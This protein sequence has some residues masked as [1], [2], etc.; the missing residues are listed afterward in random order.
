[1]GTKRSGGRGAQAADAPDAGT[2][3]RP[4]AERQR[5]HEAKRQ[6]VLRTAAQLFL[7]RGSPRVSMNDVAERLN[8][9]KP[10]LY[11]YFKSK[12]AILAECIRMGAATVGEGLTRVES[13]GGSGRER[14][15]SFIREYARLG[16]TDY[17]AC[18][19]RLDDRAL[20]DRE[21]DDARRGKRAI[22][23]RVRAIIQAGIAD[24]SI[25]R[26]DVRLATFAVI[27]ALNWIGQWYGPD[28]ANTPEEI[29]D[30]FAELLINGLGR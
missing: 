19:V 25:V 20:P 10:T 21:R 3:W 29:G 14:L 11:T 22:D 17:G 26:C 24:G 16:T 8:V 18:I 7:Q 30:A 12:D 4:R 9:T 5:D 1:M 13:Q 15:R 23:A 2:P 27:G 6:A 28:G